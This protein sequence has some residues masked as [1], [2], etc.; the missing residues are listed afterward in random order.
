MHQLVTDISAKTGIK[1]YTLRKG[2][3]IRRRHDEARGRGFKS[4]Q[5]RKWI[6]ERFVILGRV[7]TVGAKRIRTKLARIAKR[8]EVG[9][10]QAA[11]TMLRAVKKMIDFRSFLR[12]K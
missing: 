4:E 9:T 5:T 8:T 10:M 1:C 12:K 2:S 7:P 3:R 11:L 6:E